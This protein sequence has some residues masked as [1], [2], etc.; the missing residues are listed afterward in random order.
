MII[1]PYAFG[2]GGALGTLYD[3]IMQDGGTY[4]G[5][6]FRLDEASGTVADD[7]LGAT[8][9]TYGNA[10]SLGNTAI[11]PGGPVCMRTTASNQRMSYPAASMPA[12]MTAFTIG[13]VYQPTAI[14]GIRQIFSR[15]VD[16]G[17]RYW[18]FRLSGTSIQFVKTVSGVVTVQATHSM[19]AG[20][21]YLVVASVS[22][23]G[24]CK[25]FRTGTLLG[26]GAL[27]AFD[28]GGTTGANLTVGNRGTS[29]EATDNYF[30]EAF[31]IFGELSE[32]RVAEY[33]T[34]SGL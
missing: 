7:E 9:G 23:A 19:S 8:D 22:S 30:S 14:S 29:N 15:D 33:A 13:V 4:G 2:G 10:P 1:N 21:T 12:S 20:N 31:L 18:Q 24:T 6:Y 17:G 16:S 26:S 5:L 34:A 28:Y 32:A 27:G 25:L 3:E 11:Y